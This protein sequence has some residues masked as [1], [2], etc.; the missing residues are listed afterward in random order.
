MS[1]QLSL[2]TRAEGERRRDRGIAKVWDAAG[3]WREA[4][5]EAIEELAR[6]G[7]AFTAEDVR[8]IVGDPPRFNAVGAAFQIAARRGRI[9]KIGYRKATRPSLHATDLA[10]WEGATQGG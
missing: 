3:E 8:A 1:E 4:A 9:R 10:V 5:L 7:V 2:D 6:A